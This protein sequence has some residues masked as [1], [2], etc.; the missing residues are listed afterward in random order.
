MQFLYHSN[1][2]LDVLKKKLIPDLYNYVDKAKEELVYG[3]ERDLPHTD[4]QS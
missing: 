3:W 4:G 2:H 1:L